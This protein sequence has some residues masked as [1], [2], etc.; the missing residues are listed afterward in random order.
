MWAEHDEYDVTTK[1]KKEKKDKKRL[2]KNIYIKQAK[3]WTMMMM[4]IESPPVRFIYIYIYS[5]SIECCLSADGWTV[6]N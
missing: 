3:K 2:A 5:R 6:Y 1:A 4:M